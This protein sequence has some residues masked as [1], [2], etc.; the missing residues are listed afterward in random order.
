MSESVKERISKLR[1]FMKEKGLDAYVVPSADNHQSEYVG[2]FFKARA[3]VTGFTGSAGTAVVTKD[4]VG[5]WTDGRY[6]LQAE[7]QLEGSG[8]KLFKM[9][10]PGVLTVLEYIEAEMTSNGKLGFDGRLMAMQEGEDF[11]SLLAHKNV[12]V[13][14]AYDLVDMVWEG[15]P[16]LANEP[17]F[18]L[19]EKYSG[20][21]RA[22]KL[23][24]IRAAMKDKGASY[25]VITT[26]DDIAW[27]LNI[28]GNDVMYSP[29]VLCYAVV[30]MEKVDLF[31]E[32]SRFDVSVKEALAKDGVV[33][34]PYNDIYEAVKDFKAEDVVLIDP[35][36]INY[37]LYKNIP[38]KTKKVQADNPSILFKA[39][40]N[41][42]ELANIEKAHI[43]DGVAI[44]KFMYWLKTNVTKT[45]ITE[46]S[47]S[48]KLEEFRKQQEGYLW[49]S[50]AP[51]CAFKEHAAM[52][53]YCATPETDVKLAEGHLL[54]M[55]TG[56]NY[57]EGTTDITRTFAIG[58]VSKEL[59][60]HFTTVARGMMN[61]ARARFLYGCKG[62]N[63]D[64]LAREP[65]WSLDL[66]YKCGT[67]HGV[68]YL[69]N[70]HEGPSGFRWYIVPSKHETNTLEEGMVI[71]DEPG[72][73]IDGSHGI[74][75]EN[76]LIVRKGIENEF[77][78]FMH[79][80][81]V[82]YAPIDLD[83]IDT[84]DLNR[85]EKLYLNSYH[86]L[87]YEKLAQYLS[88]EERAWLK[89]YTREV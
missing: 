83:A 30:T 72:I 87:V 61:L 48:E 69:L 51:I 37:A 68:G 66:D 45:T 70:I 31:I 38:A 24:R 23:S 55:D 74:R 75:I 20:E 7:H 22:S 17:V 41:P 58:E 52:M 21:S 73:Y 62:Y 54:L 50:F 2:E 1:A 47:A 56:G 81:S 78:Q 34:R 19:E 6:F 40:K 27:L 86:K 14:Y 28:R 77:G 84:E 5:L 65:M 53:H 11:S 39:I 3:Y 60:H 82:T 57:F 13:E 43:K 26:L 44:T 79:F 59:K 80:D 9:G 16:K 64:I 76:E 46:I 29:L 15:R 25:H 71:T 49:Q 10:N 18:L 85:D 67:G 12:A 42:V 4:E 63:L 8:I 89:S 88:A 35:D 33:L 36:R 32:E